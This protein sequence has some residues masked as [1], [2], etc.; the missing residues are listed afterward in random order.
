MSG[1]F[2][3]LQAHMAESMFFNS[4]GLLVQTTIALRNKQ[5]GAV[6][7]DHPSIKKESIETMKKWH[8]QLSLPENSGV[9]QRI[10]LLQLHAQWAVEQLSGV[11]V[12]PQAN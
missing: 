3:E 9:N 11:T 8:E 12:N 4:M 1:A 6:F 5:R 7:A 2:S 10:L